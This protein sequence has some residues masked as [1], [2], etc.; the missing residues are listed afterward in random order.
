[1]FKKDPREIDACVVFD[2]HRDTYPLSIFSQRR[3]RCRKGGGSPPGFSAASMRYDAAWFWSLTFAFS[4]ILEKKTHTTRPSF[5]PLRNYSN[6]LQQ[7]MFS[8]SFVVRIWE[9]ILTSQLLMQG[10]E[11]A[12]WMQSLCVQSSVTPNHTG[13][14]TD[15]HNSDKSDRICIQRTKNIKKKPVVLK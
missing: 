3:T 9:H 2:M 13:S 7:C 14:R 12:Q 8:Y 6:D 11:W 5:L 1:M 10:S 15:T 4:C